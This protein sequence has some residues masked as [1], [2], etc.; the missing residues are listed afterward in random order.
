[1][2]L[3]TEYTDKEMK[4]LVLVA[5]LAKKK[6]VSIDEISVFDGLNQKEL[7]IVEKRQLTLSKGETYKTNKVLW[8]AE[9]KV[10]LIQL[11]EIAKK[12]SARHV[13]GIKEFLYKKEY[14]IV[15]VKPSVLIEFSIDLTPSTALSKLLINICKYGVN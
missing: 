2:K 15:A 7:S 4:F 6:Q 3:F 13:Y 12:I 14:Q 10:G 5:K 1:M 11:R 9:G 8:I